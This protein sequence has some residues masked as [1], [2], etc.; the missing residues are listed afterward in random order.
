MPLRSLPNRHHF[1][2]DPT[3][4]HPAV[5]LFP[6]I[7]FGPAHCT[8]AAWIRDDGQDIHLDVI[9]EITPGVSHSCPD[10]S[11]NEICDVCKKRPSF[12]YDD[13]FG[14][15]C[16]LCEITHPMRYRA[17]GINPWGGKLADA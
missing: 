6:R 16:T 9:A 7:N 8:E 5:R 11:H 12:R 2:R 14:Y 4:E 3:P 17:R 13:F 15:L 10:M 1:D